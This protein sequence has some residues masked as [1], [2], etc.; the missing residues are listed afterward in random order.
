MKKSVSLTL[1]MIISMIVY[2]Q[3]L[4]EKWIFK[5][6]GRVY[7]SPA[8]SANAVLFRSGDSCFYSV[9]KI[10]G[11]QNWSYRTGGAVHAD[12]AVSGDAVIFSSGDGNL[13]SVDIQTGKLNWKF[14]AE[15]EKMLD[16]WDYYLSSPIVNQGVV[17]WGSGDGHLYAID[18]QSGKLKWKFK[19]G[20][21]IHA[22]PANE[23]GI[24]YVGDYAGN[25]YALNAESGI[26]VWQFRTVGDQYFPNG[27][28]QKEAVVDSG[29]VYF[30]S[31]DYNIYALDVK[32]GRGKWNM[33]EAGS[34]II[35]IPVVYKKN[36][37]FGTSDTHRFYCLRKADGKVMWQ[38]SLPMRVYGSGVIHNNIL[39]FGCFD[40][41]I[42]GVDPLTGEI[43]Y[44]YQTKG[45]K[46]NYS[47][48]YGENGKFRKDFELYGKDYLE[49]ERTIHSLGSILSTPVIDIN[50]IYFGS[51]DGGLYAV[52][53]E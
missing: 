2:S 23:N 29:T 10:N 46:D 50:V 47:K 33:K 35:A 16:M 27:E 45:S 11:K 43:K 9:D 22:T 25:F 49:S 52:P 6:N 42:R 14:A 3:G 32:T 30:G 4:K 20:G 39:W 18:C 28:V 15:G 38:I 8:I 17:Y 5:T 41:I 1:L 21:I 40:G 44:E 12:P 7:S 24:I 48:V 53:V 31:R 26:P 36:I 13:Y 34:W 19:S 51:S 37:Y